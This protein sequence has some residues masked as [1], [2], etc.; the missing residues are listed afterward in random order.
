MISNPLI[1]PPYYAVIFS[2]TRTDNLEAYE[3]MD[4]KLSEMANKQPGFLGLESIQ[5]GKRSITI[6]Y[7][8]SL[9]AIS[10]WKNNSLHQKAQK[11]GKERWYEN[12]HIQICKVDRTYSFKK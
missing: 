12:Y 8:Q 4:N 10:Q 11:I 2:S 6:S 9:E 3:E 5:Q 1:K 7:W